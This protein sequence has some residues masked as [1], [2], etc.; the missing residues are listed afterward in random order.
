MDNN[1]MAG[2][3]L[4]NQ[5]MGNFLI[6]GYKS[7]NCAKWIDRP[8]LLF[9]I[10]YLLSNRGGIH[11]EYTHLWRNRQTRYFEVVVRFLVWVRIP[12]DAPIHLIRLCLKL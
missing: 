4:V 11:P 3:S 6:D 7:L 12:L 8:K 10:F 5:N 1:I 9:F 2:E